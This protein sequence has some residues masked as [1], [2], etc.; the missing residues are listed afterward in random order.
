MRKLFITISILINLIEIIT[1]QEIIDRTIFKCK[2]EYSYIDMK[3]NTTKYNIMV[4]EIGKTVCKYYCE[5]NKLYDS[6]L[7]VGAF[8]D[9]IE[10]RIID[11][12]LMPKRNLRLEA[13]LYFNYPKGQI[14]VHDKIFSSNYEYSEIIEIPQWKTS[15]NETKKIIGYNCKKATCRYRGREYEA[16]YATDVPVN[17]GPWKFNGLP[18]LI[19]KISDS[20][21]QF[22]FTCEYIEK[23]SVPIIKD[24]IEGESQKISRK[25]LLALHKRVWSN[26]ASMS[27]F[28]GIPTENDI[29]SLNKKNNYNPIELE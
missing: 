20:Q 28:L 25:E 18:G 13:K 8:D 26:L 7:N 10:S 5:D 29:I 17:K 27:N 2:Y 19:L 22:D 4:L 12:R 23:I 14:T 3:S 21:K 6:M 16:W 9:M 11:M 1:A 24:A 15:Y